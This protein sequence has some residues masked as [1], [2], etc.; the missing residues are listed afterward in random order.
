[1]SPLFGFVV[2]GPMLAAGGVGLFL[3]FVLG[4]VVVGA[5]VLL[6][7]QQRPASRPSP[8]TYAAPLRAEACEAPESRAQ[9]GLRRAEAIYEDKLVRK[10]L[11]DVIGASE[12]LSDLEGVI[13]AAKKAAPLLL[14]AVGLVLVFAGPAMAVVPE[15]FVPTE[16]VAVIDPPVFGVATPAKAQ[17]VPQQTYYTP[18]CSGTACG[19]R[20]LFRRR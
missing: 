13:A 18:A 3:L 12:G 1:M 6:K 20:G 9:R 15:R 7:R 8:A 19:R 4:L 17:A 2:T 11:I 16:H 10:E 14:L 5:L